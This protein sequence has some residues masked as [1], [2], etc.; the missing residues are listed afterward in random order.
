MSP[1]P[2]RGDIGLLPVEDIA[3]QLIETFASKK[4]PGVVGCYDD[5]GDFDRS[6]LEDCLLTL[7]D[8][9]PLETTGS[10]ENLVQYIVGDDVFCNNGTSPG[11][12]GWSKDM[13][14]FKERNLGQ[15]SLLSELLSY[16]SYIPS[17][18]MC[19][20]EGSGYLYGVYYQTGTAWYK[21]VFGRS[22]ANYNKP[23]ET[24]IF[25]G[26]GLSTT[27]NIH[28]GQEEGGKVLIQ[29]SVGQIVEIPQP[30]L[31]GKD[32]TPGRIKWLDVE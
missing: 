17:V 32:V 16:S 25:L 24:R 14:S 28:V 4:Y 5:N 7:P 29:T 3:I 13:I 27:P 8:N 26:A 11:F 2:A 31:P 6:N 15:A 30:N 9:H 21:D 10:F 19:S 20:P 23:I 1:V 12:D 22:P 18:D